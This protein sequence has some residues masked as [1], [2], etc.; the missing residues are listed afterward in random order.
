MAHVES[1]LSIKQRERVRVR[2]ALNERSHALINE[3]D[4]ENGRS[5]FADAATYRTNDGKPLERLNE[6]MQPFVSQMNILAIQKSSS[7]TDPQP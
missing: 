6:K 4:E 5:S 3:G 7:Q 2:I 1:N